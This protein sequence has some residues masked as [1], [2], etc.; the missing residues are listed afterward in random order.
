VPMD[1]RLLFIEA[2]AR[3]ASKPT[4]R[5][6]GSA[7]CYGPPCEIAGCSGRTVGNKP[8]CLDH[9]HLMPYAA[10]IQE[11]E[12][13][14]EQEVKTKG[15]PPIDGFVAHDLL[16]AIQLN[17]SSIPALARD[18]RVPHGVVEKLVLRMVKAGIVT[19]RRSKRSVYVKLVPA[20]EDPPHEEFPRS[21]A[22]SRA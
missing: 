19:I 8:Y 21:R 20:P 3:A 14:R 12:E 13:A 1:R 18:L 6:R 22:G 10:S 11:R 4:R 9:V 15:G 16:G 7:R 2:L 5:R 17:Q